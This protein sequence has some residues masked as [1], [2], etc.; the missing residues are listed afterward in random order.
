M[1]A[2]IKELKKRVKISKEAKE[3]LLEIGVF[4][5]SFALTPV[6]FLFGTYPFGIALTGACKRQAPFAFAGAALSALIFMEGNAVYVI[7]LVALLGLR[8]AALL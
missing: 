6:R 3:I 4:I 8:L 1:D 5:L 2:K 7:A